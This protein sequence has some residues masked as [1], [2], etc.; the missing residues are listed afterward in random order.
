MAW[1]NTW[2]NSSFEHV[3]W[4]EE[5]LSSLKMFNQD[6]FDYFMNKKV[7]YGAADIARLEI[8]YQY[9]G[10]YIDADTELLKSFPDEYFNYSF[11]AVEAYPDPRWVRRITNGILGAEKNSPIIKTYIDKISVAKQIEPCWSTIGGTLLTK[12]LL[13]DFKDEA[14]ILLLPPEIFYPKDINDCDAITRHFGG[15]TYNLY[16]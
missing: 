2:K 5:R 14:N 8:L 15:S 4:N 1:I 12:V 16:K 3:L 10:A 6:K 7:Y 13:E 9:G 11:F